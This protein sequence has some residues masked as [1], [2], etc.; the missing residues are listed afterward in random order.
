MA[1][2]KVTVFS[3]ASTSGS[4]ESDMEFEVLNSDSTQ[5]YVPS[6]DSGNYY[7]G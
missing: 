3:S 6:K 1:S 5:D 2:S 7:N 4:M